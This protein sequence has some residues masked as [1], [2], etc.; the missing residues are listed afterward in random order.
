VFYVAIR[1][2]VLKLGRPRRRP[3]APPAATEAPLP[4]P[5]E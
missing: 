2:L 3:A 1:W 4:A 5:A